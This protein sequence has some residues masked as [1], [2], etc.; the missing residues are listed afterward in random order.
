MNKTTQTKSGPFAQFGSLQ[1]SSDSVAPENGVHTPKSPRCFDKLPP[2]A[3]GFRP[4]L[5]CMM[6]MVPAVR[7]IPPLT[8]S[9]LSDENS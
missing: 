2:C 8:P 4:L 1:S 5:L 9:I 6:Q 3:A 7:Q